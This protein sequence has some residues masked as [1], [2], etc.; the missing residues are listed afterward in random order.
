MIEKGTKG[1]FPLPHVAHVLACIAHKNQQPRSQGSLRVQNAAI[2]DF[3]NPET[4]GTRLEEK[5]LWMIS[6]HTV[7]RM[8]IFSVKSKILTSGTRSYITRFV[9]HRKSHTRL[10]AGSRGWIIT[11]PGPDASSRPT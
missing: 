5:A 8:S 6:D 2:L 3:I 10:A 1:F 4:L 7:L 9:V 11:P